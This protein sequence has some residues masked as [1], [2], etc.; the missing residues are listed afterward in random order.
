MQG[1][2][3]NCCAQMLF[4]GLGSVGFGEATGQLDLGSNLG[5]ST[6]GAD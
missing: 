6:E 1:S 4:I 3:A 5:P 2:Y